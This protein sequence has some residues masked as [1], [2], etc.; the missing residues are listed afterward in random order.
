MAQVTVQ[1]PR[2]T[3]YRRRSTAYG[4]RHTAGAGEREIPETGW[5]S[6]EIGQMG[7]SLK[8]DAVNIAVETGQRLEGPRVTWVTFD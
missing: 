6:G 7:K 3:A 8:Y 4:P 1:S 5:A 2:P